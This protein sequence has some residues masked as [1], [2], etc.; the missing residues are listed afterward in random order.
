MPSLPSRKRALYKVIPLNASNETVDLLAIDSYL[1][2]LHSLVS[3]FSRWLMLVY[4]LQV[5]MRTV[6]LVLMLLIHGIAGKTLGL[7]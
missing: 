7:L 2:V 5:R 1:K 3:H 6:L 4:L